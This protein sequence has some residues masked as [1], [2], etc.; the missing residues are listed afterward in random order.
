MALTD[1]QTTH[2]PLSATRASWHV[3]GFDPPQVV[4]PPPGVVA[5]Q[6]RK[7]VK[8]INTGCFS[9]KR[10]SFA[11]CS[12]CSLC[13]Q[14]GRPDTARSHSKQDCFINPKGPKFRCKIALHQVQELKAAGKPVPELLQELEAEAAGVAPPATTTISAASGSTTATM[15]PSQL[16]AMQSDLAALMAEDEMELPKAMRLAME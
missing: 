13:M 3:A 10:G 9:A 5:V 1:H 11:M 2:T 16:A 8:T 15:L 7:V 14:V 4:A 6:P 12:P